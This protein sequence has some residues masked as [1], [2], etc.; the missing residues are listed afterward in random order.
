M[1]EDKMPKKDIHPRTGWNET[2]GRT[3]EGWKEEVESDV[4]QVLE[5]K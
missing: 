1:E 4:V 3:R 2:R 5:V